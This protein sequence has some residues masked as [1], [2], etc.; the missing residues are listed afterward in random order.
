MA[1]IYLIL[2]GLCE[3]M[4]VG[5][6]GRLQQQ[7]NTSSFV[8]LVLGFTASFFFLS[9]AMKVLPMGLAYAIWTGIGAAGGAILGIAL[10]NEPK[11]ALRITAITLIIGSVI[12]LKLIS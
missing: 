8:L 4:A 11:N 2:A 10:Y 1:W 9:L 12:A 6:M 3:M 7:K 5:F